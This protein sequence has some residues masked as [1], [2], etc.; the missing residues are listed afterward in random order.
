MMAAF[1]FFDRRTGAERRR[2]DSGPPAGQGERR[3]I[4]ARRAL[5]LDSHS[6]ADW[7]AQPSSPKPRKTPG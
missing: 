6:V 5:N 3:R 4:L 2:Q 7:L 1:N